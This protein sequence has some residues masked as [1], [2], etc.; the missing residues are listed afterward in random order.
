MSQQEV[1]VAPIQ[2]GSAVA[3]SDDRMESPLNEGF[4]DELEG[5][6]ADDVA[7]SDGNHWISVVRRKLRDSQQDFFAVKP[8]QY[9]LDFLLSITIAY[10]AGSV[11]LLS[12]LGSWQQ[13]L[14]Y[15]IAIIWIYRLSSLVHEVAHLSAN[16]MRT[17]KVVWNLL[18]GVMVLSPSPFFTRHHRDHHTARLYGTP[19]D[20]E[21]MAN[22]FTPG[23]LGGL[24][25]YAA[26]VAVFPVIVFL[27]FLLTPLTY[28]HPAL[29]E[30]VLTRAS[31]L[32]MNWHYE[33]RLNPTDRWSISVVEWLCC[34]RAWVIPLSV[35]FGAAPPSRLLLL[36]L[37]AIGALGLNQ[38]RLLADHHLDSNG[39]L[40]DWES[41][42]LDSC[43]FTGRDLST[44]L[45]FPFS[46]RYHAL[47]HLFPT[48]PYHN[49]A[50]AHG[51]LVESLPADSPYRGL[52]QGSWWQV[53]KQLFQPRPSRVG[54]S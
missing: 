40:L 39:G 3:T 22:V 12:P 45:L 35:A 24:V 20:P 6:A 13:L 10:T 8:R 16:E 31:S 51:Y 49:L 21:Y 41:H 19:R 47:H 18:A 42:I 14:A 54:V 50:A 34:L 26:M 15:P 17:F 43:N 11:F 46:I 53:A 30:F 44:R 5:P 7:S 52:D 25:R 23:S 2:S 37:L 48:L 9:W 32:T 1:A 27:R 4:A 33:R 28:L 36:Y 29:R 38:L